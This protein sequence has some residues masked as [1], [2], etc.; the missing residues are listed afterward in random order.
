MSF[1]V[2]GLSRGS[3]LS[4]GTY[5][6]SAPAAWKYITTDALADVLLQEELPDMSWQQT[7]FVPAMRLL[8]PSDTLWVEAYDG[9]QLLIVGTVYNDPWGPYVSV[10]P[11][12]NI[13]AL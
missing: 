1:D 13:S 7:Y 8:Q 11:V 4:I 3:I 6:P 5:G 2:A 12:A 10:Q 9:G